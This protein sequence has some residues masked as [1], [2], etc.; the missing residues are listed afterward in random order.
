MSMNAS[1]DLHNQEFQLKSM[2]VRK[3]LIGDIHYDAVKKQRIID[4]GADFFN[5][6]VAHGMKSDKKQKGK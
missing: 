6:T 1:F 3:P 5:F 4:L 2:N